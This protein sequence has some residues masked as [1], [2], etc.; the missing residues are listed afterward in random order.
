MFYRFTLTC[1]LNR[2]LPRQYVLIR[3]NLK[4]IFIECGSGIFG[5]LPR[6]S[7]IHTLCHVGLEYT[8]VCMILWIWYIHPCSVDLIST[9][10]SLQCG[11]DIHIYQPCHV[12]LVYTYL[13]PC[14]VGV[15]SIN[16]ILAMWI[17]YIHMFIFSLCGSGIWAYIFAIAMWIQNTL[18]LSRIF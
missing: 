3:K 18:L 15:M 7:D 5:F 11:S 4:R 16:C 1:R 2:S 17:L 10:V 8:D 13:Y 6:G 14:H 9:V 12:G